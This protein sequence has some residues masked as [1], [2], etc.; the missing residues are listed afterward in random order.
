MSLAF[1]NNLVIFLVIHLAVLSHEA[2]FPTNGNTT[3]FSVNSVQFLFI[4]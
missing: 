4:Y 3:Q 2:F 1:T